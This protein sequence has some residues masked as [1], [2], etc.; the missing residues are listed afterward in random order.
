MVWERWDHVSKGHS[1]RDR[2]ECKDSNS[3][4]T[5]YPYSPHRRKEGGITS[6]LLLVRCRLSAHIR[7][8]TTKSC[9]G[10]S[11]Q[12]ILSTSTSIWP[13][14]RRGL[15]GLTLNSRSTSPLSRSL[16]PVIGARAEDSHSKPNHSSL[17]SFLGLEIVISTL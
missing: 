4:G 7:Q 17:S 3:A 15:S 12:G 5:F 6:R 8:S 1:R 13:L 2:D 11:S 9:R 14:S 10:L 16:F